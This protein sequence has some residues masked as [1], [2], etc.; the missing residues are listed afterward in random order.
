MPARSEKERMV[1]AIVIWH[2]WISQNCSR[3]NELTRN[4]NFV[5]IHALAYVEMIE[6]H[7]LKPD[8]LS[9]IP[10]WTPLPEG[11]VHINPDAAIL[12]NSCQMGVG[13][14]IRNHLSE[15]LAACSELL[16]DVMTSKPVE[17]LAMRRA[18]SFVGN[19][20]FGK[21]PV[22][23]DYLPVIQCINSME[24]DQSSVGGDLSRHQIFS[25]DNFS[26]LSEEFI[27]SC[28]RKFPMGYM[29]HTLCNDFL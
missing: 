22:V 21:I 5:V 23:S 29:W 1:L 27:C 10:R 19:E 15:C 16:N 14:V 4:P 8:L 28:F 18:I 9:G 3:N 2:L 26:S 7:L 12:S 17:A 6:M 25:R 24:I 11:S 13:V 20:G